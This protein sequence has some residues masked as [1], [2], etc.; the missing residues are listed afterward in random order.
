MD[1]EQMDNVFASLSPERR[2]AI[3]IEMEK[4][5][6]QDNE[7]RDSLIREGAE[8]QLSTL[9]ASMLRVAREN[10][11]GTELNNHQKAELWA[12]SR[13]ALGMEND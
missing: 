7:Y 13:H 3:K 10:Q 9:Y 11:G 5:V 1:N 8:A 4:R 2:Q 6:R 12:Q